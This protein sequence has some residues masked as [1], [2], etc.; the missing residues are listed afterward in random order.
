MFFPAK[1]QYGKTFFL[2]HF[3]INF[4]T[5][6]YR[7]GFL[8]QKIVKFIALYII[9]FNIPTF[10]LLSNNLFSFFWIINFYFF[11]FTLFPFFVFLFFFQIHE[12]I[13][14]TIFIMSSK[15]SGFLYFCV[16]KKGGHYLFFQLRSLKSYF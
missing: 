16:N 6:I 1:S 9:F 4:K 10:F 13:I 7:L 15:L 5:L 2:G 14:I 12:H 8:V 11:L 3:L